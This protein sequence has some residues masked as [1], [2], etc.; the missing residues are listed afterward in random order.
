MF[1]AQ[2]RRKRSYHRNLWLCWWGPQRAEPRCPGSSADPHERGSDVG[3]LGRATQH[4]VQLQHQGARHSA[5]RLLLGP[6]DWEACWVGRHRRQVGCLLWPGHDHAATAAVHEDHD[7]WL[8]AVA[9]DDQF[10]GDDHIQRRSDQRRR[11]GRFDRNHED[12][13]KLR[14]RILHCWCVRTRGV[15]GLVLVVHDELVDVADGV[16]FRFFLVELVED[17]VVLAELF[18][19]LR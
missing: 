18:S 2:H 17:D 15:R 8:L 9:A 1:R 7:L 5:H 4:I 11:H 14:G 3:P 12:V 13:G 10:R 19:R 6:F 16:D